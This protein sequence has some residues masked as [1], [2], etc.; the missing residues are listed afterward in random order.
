MND[1]A[2][3]AYDDLA[4]VEGIF[5]H[6]AQPFTGVT[7][8]RD[9]RGRKICEV[10]FVAGR[11]HGTARSWHPN[12]RSPAE[13]PYIHG[14]RHGTH[15]QWFDDASLHVQ[16]ENEFGW[17]MRKQVRSRTGEIVETYERPPSDSVYQTILRKRADQ[18]RQP[19]PR[20]FEVFPSPPADPRP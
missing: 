13:T 17:M 15:R 16:I 3:I 6:N 8:D 4:Y 1:H 7:I 20:G 18:A 10:P 12:G 14:A 2:E 5:L 11:E 19:H 9:A